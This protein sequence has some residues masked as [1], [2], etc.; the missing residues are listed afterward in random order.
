MDIIL[1]LFDT[2]PAPFWPESLFGWLAWVVFLGWLVLLLWPPRR[3]HISWKLNLRSLGLL[4]ALFFLAITANLFI[5]IRLPVGTAM[6]LPGIPQEPRGLAI[7]LFSAVPLFLAGGLLGPFSA[8]LLGFAGGVLR[9]LWDTH[10]IFTPLELALLGAL[11]SLAVR[12]R[13][14]TWPFVLLRKPI[15]AAMVLLLLYL[16]IFIVD[17]FMVSTGSLAARLDYA[18]T[19]VGSRSLALAAEFLIAGIVTQAVVIG[20]PS[21]VRR[22][23]PLQPSPLERSLE[24]RFL[25][26][27]SALIICLLLALLAGDWIVAGRA[28][29]EML[30]NRL[31]GIAEISAQ[32]VPFILETGQNLAGNISTDSDVAVLAG[33]DLQTSLEN[34]LRSVPFFDELM[35]F[36]RSRNL[37]GSYSSGT[38]DQFTLFPEET[39]GLE[40]VFNGVLS[41]VYTI[42]PLIQDQGLPAR[43]SFLSA[44]LDPVTGQPGRVLV[45]RS[46]LTNNP[47]TLPLTTAL[48]SMTG[49][50]GY[51]IL[52]DEKNRILFHPDDNQVMNQYVG[53]IMKSPVFFDESAP[54]GTRNLVYF[55]PV[56]GRS[57]SVVLAV[58]AM[59]AQQVAL[60]IA[61]PLTVLVL[62]LAVAA[63]I[64]LSLGLKTITFSLQTLAMETV[65][66]AQGQLDHVLTVDS[67]DEIGQFR[68]SFEQMRI[69]L[70]AR[71]SELNRLLLVSQGVASSLDVREAVQPVLEAILATGAGAV[72]M[73]LLP[74]DE[75][76]SQQD[77][78]VLALGPHADAYA[79][80]DD[81]V[82]QLADR[83]EA[84]FL[85][86][87][88]GVIRIQVAS[89][90]ARLASAFI[91]LLRHENRKY[92][93]LWAGY[94]KPHQFSDSDQRFLNTLSGQ[95]ALAAANY[96]LFRSVEAGRQR[97]AAILASTPDPVLVIDQFERLLLANP[98]A[99]KLLSPN[100]EMTR[101]LPVDKVVSQPALLEVLR[102]DVLEKLTGEV[103]LPDGR[104][105]LATASPVESEGRPMGRV[106]ILRDVT[107]FKELDLM[108]TEFVNTVSHDLRSPLTLIR[109]YATM[110]EM[111]GT[112]NDQQQTYARKI[113]QGVEGMSRLVNTLL[114]LG[115]V[116]A[117]VGLQLEIVPIADLIQRS[118]SPQLQ[119]AVQKNIELTINTDK[120]SNPDAQIEADPVLFQQVIQNLLENA[121]KYTPSGGVILAQAQLVEK[122]LLFTVKD[123]GIGIDPMDQPHLFEKFYR[124]RQREAREQKGSGLGLAIVKSIVEHHGGKVWLESQL[125]KG[126]I[127]YMQMPLRQERV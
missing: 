55:Q 50:G 72:R 119:V 34:H 12:Q 124:G 62:I 35:V 67:V 31:R 127:F 36:D 95:A 99:A 46:S 44:I 65:R 80:F 30:L 60:N 76:A 106:C 104:V 25:F 74:V 9:F 91:I 5:G 13:Y 16:P 123:S 29:R 51:G 63:L 43:I 107:H 85:A 49:L 97:L 39:A 98:A 109:G 57:W 48:N 8:A 125:G 68:R 78:A 17:S 61:A 89:K 59:Q 18:L 54:N 112:L 28:A 38:V 105:Y 56:T 101:G 19:G 118:L 110:L 122:D 70:Q 1:W 126:S 26:W 103:L 7:M 3:G 41:Q 113:V 23:L 42:P 58:P 84:L 32:S 33:T 21:L 87:A 88:A 22:H 77:E 79:R 15:F 52:L 90:G 24:A 120:C 116:E 86:D 102:S 37:L 100:A 108:K 66:I 11:F 83:S 93:V 117:G 94:D 71:L 47:F 81:Q 10:N 6:P 64:L 2:L 121:I 115:R 53:Q 96:H 45:A 20:Y 73:I 82:A 114:D 111:V 75:E 92:G 4:I 69:S 27:T 40:L 14:R